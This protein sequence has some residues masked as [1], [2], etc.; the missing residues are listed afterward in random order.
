MGL[1]LCVGCTESVRGWSGAD[2]TAVDQPDTGGLVVANDLDRD[3][4]APALVDKFSCFAQVQ[5]HPM[6]AVSL[7]IARICM[8]TGQLNHGILSGGNGVY[9]VIA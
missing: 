1:G 2:P 8:E 6:Y 4:R 7:S 5:S 9:G 3:V